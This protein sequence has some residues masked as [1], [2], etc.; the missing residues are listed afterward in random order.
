MKEY[1]EL[2]EAFAKLGINDK[3]NAVSDEIMKISY[4]LNEYLR[5]YDSSIFEEPFNYDS[6]Q[7]QNFTESEFLDFTYKD[8]YYIKNEIMILMNLI[9]KR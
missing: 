9:N 8:I 7:H 1:E 2:F 4:L 6:N 5:K 3:R